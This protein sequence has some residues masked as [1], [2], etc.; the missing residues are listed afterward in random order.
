MFGADTAGAVQSIIG[1]DTQAAAR[2][3][4]GILRGAGDTQ[5]FVHNGQRV[6]VSGL[7]ANNP[8]H[9]PQFMSLFNHSTTARLNALQASGK[10]PTS[11]DVRRVTQ[12][13]LAGG[14]GQMPEEA[15][16]RF[17]Q[18]HMTPEQQRVAAEHDGRVRQHART[19]MAKLDKA[20]Q[21]RQAQT[22]AAQDEQRQAAAEESAAQEKARKD[23]AKR[24]RGRGAQPQK[25]G[26]LQTLNDAMRYQVE[27]AAI[28]A[29]LDVM[30]LPTDI[31]CHFISSV[32]QI[33]P[34]NP[35]E[36]LQVFAQTY[37]LTMK[38]IDEN[39]GFGRQQM[40]GGAADDMKNHRPPEPPK[41][42]R[43]TGT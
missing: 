34:S 28:M 25:T 15:A 41:P 6:A 27:L 17:R 24:Q 42:P 30:W 35:M 12:E 9:A 39:L 5:E 4:A 8:E 23:E 7:D 43:P 3:R 10:P 29:L 33:S 11:E 26:F 13:A 32:K 37:S 22:K 31:L 1:Q 16:Q 36:L 19:E 2:L 40:G 20:Q 21:Q 18:D 14:L 38:T